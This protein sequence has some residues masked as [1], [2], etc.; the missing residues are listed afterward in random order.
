MS[1]HNASPES[2]FTPRTFT[3]DDGAR[4]TL[5]AIRPE[6]AGIEQ[7]FVRGLSA[8]SKRLRF[9]SSLV[10]LPPKLLYK[11]THPNFPHDWALIAT[12]EKDMGENSEDGQEEGE[13]DNGEQEIGVA[14]Y[15]ATAESDT[16][17]FAVT[18]ADAW[19]GRGIATRL[20][21]A[22][23]EVATRAGLRYLEGFVLRENY[24]MRKLA[25]KLDF[26]VT[27]GLSDDPSTVRVVK[28]LT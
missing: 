9:F 15:V 27:A 14:R 2:V 17:E 19:Q 18:V 10:E 25:R 8:R 24:P 23:I 26:S 7:A 12:I 6:D 4:V 22:L 11:F 13:Y 5:R 28:T 20:M 21:Q 1:N 3:L 16:A